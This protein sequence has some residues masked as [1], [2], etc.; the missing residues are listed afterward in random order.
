MP[1]TQHS[2]EI[3]SASL[4]RGPGDPSREQHPSLPIPV[5]SGARPAPRREL[6]GITG[7]VFPLALGGS[8]FGWTASA[9]D[10]VAILDRY[11]ALGGNFIDTADSYSGGLSEVQIGA[12]MRH[13]RNRDHIVV[14][15][16]I[17]RH[18]DYPGLARQNVIAAVDA[19]LERLGTDRIDLLYLHRDDPTVPLESTLSAVREL[20]A[21]GKVLSLGAS[22]FPAE[23]LVQARVLA[24]AGYPR[25]TAYETEYSLVNRRSFEG[26]RALV[27][28]GQ[29]LAVMPYFALASGYLT[30]KYRSRADF[31][32]STRESRAEEHFTRRGRRV[33]RALDEIAAAA[34]STP[35]TVALAWLLHQPGVLAPVVSAS[36]PEQVDALAASVHLTLENEQLHELDRAS[37]S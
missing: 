2:R 35:A 8:V 19:S 9:E 7:G 37:R 3:D 1:V 4:N 18:A 12:W 21:A 6:A 17:G 29:G 11:A 24:A 13:R 23:R 31:H 14:A 30:G 16:K 22:D 25:I 33:L 32:G 27:A 34:S 15:T 28:R 5:Q 20:M 36:H 10:T 26:D